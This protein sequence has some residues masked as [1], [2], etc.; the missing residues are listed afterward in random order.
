MSTRKKEA[1]D[2]LRSFV[3]R[4]ES[5]EEEKRSLADDIKS[6]YAEAKANGYDTKALRKIIW[7][8]RQDTNAL[9]EYEAIIET[10]MHALGMTKE[11]PLFEAVGAMTVD[12]TA[13]TEVIEAFKTLV[14]SGAEIVV[15]M[16]GQAVRLSRDSDGVA[17]AEDVRDEE[18]ATKERVGKSL[19]KP[20]PVLTMV[21]KP[22][23]P[24]PDEIKRIA[25]KAEAASE[26]KRE[27]APE[28]PEPT[29]A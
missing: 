15:R 2:H 16:G 28:E 19:G 8:R 24:S 9:A 29:P 20:A 21:P 5:L 23:G 6:V 11:R 7:R 14:P 18:P 1:G 22:K 13:R 3:E 4:I 26:T 27:P 10:Y 12:K 25:D 17:R